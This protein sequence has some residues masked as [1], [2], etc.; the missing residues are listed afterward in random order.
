MHS[1]Q[2][3]MN[4]GFSEASSARTERARP[5][6]GLGRLG[7]KVVLFTSTALLISFGKGI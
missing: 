6:A 2:G 3:S 5:V 1:K 7:L 4:R